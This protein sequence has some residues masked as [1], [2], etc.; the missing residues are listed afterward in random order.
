MSKKN[1]KE[2]VVT[3]DSDG[4]ELK[5]AVLYPNPAQDNIAQMEMLRSFNEA[6]K[7][8]AVVRAALDN[9]LK[10]QGL[11]S[12]DKQKEV[13]VIDDRLNANRIKLKTGRDGDKQLTKS[14]GRE[15]AI[16]MFAD[17]QERAE[18]LSVK[19][20]LDSFTAEGQAQ[21]TKFHSLV[22][23]CTTYDDS[24]KPYFSSLADYFARGNE[25]ATL[26]AANK[27]FEMQY[28][29][30]TEFMA[31]LPE[32]EFLL[33]YKFVNTDLKFINKDGHLIS[34]DGKLIRE[35]GRYVNE[36]SELVDLHGNRVNEE[37]DPLV[38]TVEFLDD[39]PAEVVA[40]AEVSS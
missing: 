28:N 6:L 4:K 14:Q 38:D 12:E 30:D 34:R 37:G 17:R 26:A 15:I 3:K 22:A 25:E 21:N 40:P 20:S 27:L 23:Q 16:K 19:D 35:D 9:R 13:D 8:G 7:G 1:K 31:K 18:L 5:L 33:K 32:N 11:W 2:V 10:D 29:V 36:N 39:E 24:G